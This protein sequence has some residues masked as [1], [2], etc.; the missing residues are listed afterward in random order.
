MDYR[1]LVNEENDI[2]EGQDQ[3]L[4]PFL[5]FDTQ[6]DQNNSEKRNKFFIFL[7]IKIHFFL[8]SKRIPMES[9]KRS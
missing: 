5:Q 6:E 4:S 9:S 8:F 3:T 2:P 1:T 7:L